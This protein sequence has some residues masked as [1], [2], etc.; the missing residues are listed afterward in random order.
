MKIYNVDAGAG[1]LRHFRF[2]RSVATF[3]GVSYQKLA[4]LFRES[5][6]AKSGEIVPFEGLLIWKAEVN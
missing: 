4:K 6:A 3:Y 2:L 1:E 5:E